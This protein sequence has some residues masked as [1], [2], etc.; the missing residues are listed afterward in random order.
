MPNKDAAFEV[1]LVVTEGKRG[2]KITV[3]APYGPAVVTSRW[4]NVLKFC[5]PGSQHMTTEEDTS[6]TFVLTDESGYRLYGHTTRSVNGHAYCFLSKYPWCR[7]F[8]YAIYVF[9][10]NHEDI[11]II[12]KLHGCPIPDPCGI[13]TLPASDPFHDDFNSFHFQRPNDQEFSFVDTWPHE[14]LE[15]FTFDQLFIMMSAMLAETQI[16]VCSSNFSISSRIC[17]SLLA[18]IYPFE[19][20]HVLVPVCP[21]ELLDVMSAPTPYIVGYINS[22]H[23]YVRKQPLSEGLVVVMV[24]DNCKSVRI[25]GGTSAIP[26]LPKSGITSTLRRHVQV[27]YYS[28]KQVKM[29]KRQVTQLQSRERQEADLRGLLPIFMRY[30]GELFGAIGGERKFDVQYFLQHYATK[31]TIKFMNIIVTTQLF[32][33]LRIRTQEKFKDDEAW[34]RDGFCRVSVAC[35][36]EAFPSLVK[37]LPAKKKGVGIHT[38]GTICAVPTEEDMIE[39]QPRE[40]S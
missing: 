17:L 34:I 28:P 31:D 39:L 35:H 22:Q 24:A 14:L 10:A 30:Y 32:D 19:W 21:A 7:F 12:Q 33:T 16:A 29:R 6:F 15:I 40:D 3:S 27:W 13:F 4:P 23:E 9:Q 37:R 5:F 36:P 25:V 18:L 20:Q 11:Q 1:F 38:L 26:R 2:L 8:Y